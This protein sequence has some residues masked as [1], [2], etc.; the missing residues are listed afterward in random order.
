VIRLGSLAGYSFEGPW[1]LA[2]W[3]PPD[4][5]GL[6]AV[7]YKPDPERKLETYAVIYVGHSDNLANEGFP[8]KHPH[9]RRR[10]WIGDYQTEV[11]GPLSQRGPDHDS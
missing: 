11:T 6:F 10:E 7:M 9:A 4:Q 1:L 5:P 8:W 3:T 2:G